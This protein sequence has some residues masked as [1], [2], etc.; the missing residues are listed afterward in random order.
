MML[1]NDAGPL[2]VADLPRLTQHKVADALTAAIDTAREQAHTDS[3]DYTQEAW[4]RVPIASPTWRILEDA[5]R[6][7]STAVRARLKGTTTHAQAAVREFITHLRA[8]L[9]CIPEGSRRS[10]QLRSEVLIG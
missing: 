1:G 7:Y 3:W 4:S 2:T 9:R 8:A 5:A 10:S 6:A